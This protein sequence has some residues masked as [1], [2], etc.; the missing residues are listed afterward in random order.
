MY[1]RKALLDSSSFANIK[2]IKSGTSW[3]TEFFAKK[4]DL[5]S[6]YITIPL[7]LEN[8]NIYIFKFKLIL[9][10]Q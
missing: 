3:V 7:S 10:T 9:I 1:V 4:Y 2:H 6:F 5:I 8:S